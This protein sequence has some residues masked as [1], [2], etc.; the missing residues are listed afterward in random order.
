MNKIVIIT[1]LVLLSLLF[2]RLGIYK[3]EKKDEQAGVQNVEQK[4]PISFTSSFEIYTNG[5][6]RIFSDSRYHNKSPEVFI[7]STNPS[8]V[9]VK[10]EG[11]TWDDF[12]KTL[13]MSLDKVCLVTGT[14]QTFCNNEKGK[15]KFYLNNIE[16]PDALDKEIKKDTFLKVIYE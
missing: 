15:L 9:I 10:K 5:T 3:S 8:T 11:I 12:F 4:I 7:E 1:F 6:R 13:P 14:K 16:T 2:Y